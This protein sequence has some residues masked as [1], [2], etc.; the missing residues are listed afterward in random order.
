MQANAIGAGRSGG[1]G[2]GGSGKEKK[3]GDIWERFRGECCELNHCF[4]L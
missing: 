1:G 2:G 3:L 4:K